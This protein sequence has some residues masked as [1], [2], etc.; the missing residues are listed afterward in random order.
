MYSGGHGGGAAPPELFLS[1]LIVFNLFI[2]AGYVIR[3]FVIRN[4]KHYNK[5][6]VLKNVFYAL[7]EYHTLKPNVNIPTMFLIILNG[8][9]LM[10][11][12]IFLITDLLIT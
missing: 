1:M 3:F 8:L 7:N 12:L 6:S 9:F 11:F 10:L 2:F 4:S 5:Q